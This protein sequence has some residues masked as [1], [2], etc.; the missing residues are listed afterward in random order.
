MYRGATDP[1]NGG[2]F[3]MFPEYGPPHWQ[4]SNSVL[5]GSIAVEFDC[6]HWGG[7]CFIGCGVNPTFY[8]RFLH[9]RSPTTPIWNILM[10][11]LLICCNKSE[12]NG[13]VVG[14]LWW[15]EPFS[16]G[17]HHI[18]VYMHHVCLIQSISARKATHIKL[19][20]C[21]GSSQFQVH[22]GSKIVSIGWSGCECLPSECKN[23]H[24]QAFPMLT[25][26]GITIQGF[27]SW[28]WT[29]RPI[30]H[31]NQLCTKLCTNLV[32]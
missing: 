21:S 24:F 22:F 20:T 12:K 26:S 11:T 7:P 29:E 16:H 28:C 2:I 15:F 1:P 30:L 14:V 32:S 5:N 18:R 3:L 10:I 25:T 17:N 9:T 4:L 31:S 6:C 23:A 8:H 13:W 27:K 19:G